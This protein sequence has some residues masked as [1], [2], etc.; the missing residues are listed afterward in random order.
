MNDYGFQILSFHS[1]HTNTCVC[2][3]YVLYILSVFVN[4]CIHEHTSLFMR[5]F[6]FI[7][8]GKFGICSNK[9]SILLLSFFWKSLILLNIALLGT[10][11]GHVEKVVA[12][13]LHPSFLVCSD[14]PVKGS[15]IKLVDPHLPL[16]VDIEDEAPLAFHPEPLVDLPDRLKVCFI[17]VF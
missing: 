3:A 12:H 15:K 2:H 14:R 13:L 1:V 4:I 5:S 7:V 10:S 8:E 11:V 9:M 17:A 6:S 16:L